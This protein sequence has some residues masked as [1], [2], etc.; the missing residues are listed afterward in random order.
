MGLWD[1]LGLNKKVAILQPG[2]GYTKVVV[3]TAQFQAPLLKLAGGK[4]TEKACNINIDALLVPEP[5]NPFDANAV[6]VVVEGRQVGYL[7][8]QMAA[9]MAEFWR[10]EPISKVNCGAVIVGGWKGPDG[11]EG[12]FGVKL[13]VSWPPKLLK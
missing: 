13:C 3:G 1:M 5:G 9:E 7:P 6:S 4:K 12:H 11:D 10:S 2:R 8:K